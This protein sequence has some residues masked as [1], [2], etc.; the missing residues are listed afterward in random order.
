MLDPNQ[1]EQF[2]Y[3][4]NDFLRAARTVLEFLGKERR[5]SA[6]RAYTPAARGALAM[7][8]WIECYVKKLSSDDRQRLDLLNRLRKVSTHDL[9]VTPERGDISLE[10]IDSRT[11]STMI[12]GNPLYQH[13]YG[14][15]GAENLIQS[16]KI[17]AKY[18][19]A[20]R[21]SE[22]VVSFCRKAVEILEN[23]VREA[24]SAHP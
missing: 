24:Y 21:E 16:T 22:D 8:H 19:F 13:D 6:V 11:S 9:S 17:S 5:A 4:L 1:T 10:V 12:H 3:R 14:S 2:V 20:S 7:Q 18:F 23:M 15:P